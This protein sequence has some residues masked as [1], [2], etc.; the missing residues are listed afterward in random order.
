[1]SQE[2]HPSRRAVAA[3][4]REAGRVATEERGRRIDTLRWHDRHIQRSELRLETRVAEGAEARGPYGCVAQ[5]MPPA[6]IATRLA[7][8]TANEQEATWAV[9]NAR[10]IRLRLGEEY[11]RSDAR[12]AQEELD[13][14][15]RLAQ[16]EEE[17]RTGDLSR[18]IRNRRQPRPSTSLDPAAIAERTRNLREIRYAE[19]RVETRQCAERR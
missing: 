13:E 14:M 5:G 17:A 6:Q 18:G 1:M 16:A 12:H 4:Q 3:V 2:V 11:A 8:H 9:R 19:E 7:E 10:A 15:T